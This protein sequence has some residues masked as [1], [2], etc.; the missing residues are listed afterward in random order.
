[1]GTLTLS[2]L[3]GEVQSGLGNRTDSAA[4]TTAVVQAL[5]LAQQRVER[6]WPWRDLQRQL[7]APMTYTGNPAIDKYMTLPTRVKTIHSFVLLDTTAGLSS[8]GQSQK[9]IQKPWRWFDDHYPSPEWLTPGWP[10]VYAYWGQFIVM[11][12]PPQ[13]KYT[14]AIRV[15]VRPTPFSS[16]NLN[17]TSDYESKDDILINWALGYKWR[18]YG[19]LDR[20]VYHENLVD[21]LIEEA[22]DLDDR[23]PDLEVSKDLGQL[24]AVVNVP[25]WQNPFIPT[26]P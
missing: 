13:A 14:A 5:N 23:R 18:A 26:Q 19:R 24:P 11:A 2:Q 10:Q 25:Y 15:I 7:V 1:L 17:A 22:I 3:V 9:V 8:M 20:A 16:T 6:R 21:H 4:G 12:P